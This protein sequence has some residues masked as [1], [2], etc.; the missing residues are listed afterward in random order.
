MLPSAVMHLSFLKICAISEERMRKEPRVLVCLASGSI[1]FRFIYF[2]ADIF[3]KTLYHN[4][5]WM[6]IL[7]FYYFF[8]VLLNTSNDIRWCYHGTER[9]YSSAIAFK[10]QR[11]PQYN[12]MKH[13]VLFLE[14]SDIYIFVCTFFV[15]FCHAFYQ[16]ATVIICHCRYMP[17]N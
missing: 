8:K 1:T 11:I 9:T 2:F 16:M 7:L 10:L 17:N 14:L 6:F 3:V 13:L 5:K 12:T 4:S 15:L